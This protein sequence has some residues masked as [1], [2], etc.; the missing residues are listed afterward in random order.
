M[1]YL[2]LDASSAKVGRIVLDSAGSGWL[3]LNERIAPLRVVPGE[4]GYE[5]LEERLEL[6]DSVCE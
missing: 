6:G 5:M 3:Y 2:L 4:C 1:T